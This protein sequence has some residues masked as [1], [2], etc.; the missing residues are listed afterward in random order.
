MRSSKVKFCQS[1]LVCVFIVLSTN[2]SYSH[3]SQFNS[4][5]SWSLLIGASKAS[6]LLNHEESHGIHQYEPL[7]EQIRLTDVALSISLIKELLKG[8]RMSYSLKT[9]I[10]KIDG[11]YSSNS[12]RNFR[13]EVSGQLFGLGGSVNYNCYQEFGFKIQPYIGAEIVHEFGNYRLSHKSSGNSLL[14]V[15]NYKENFVLIVA[16]VRFFDKSHKLMSFFEMSM[17]ETLTNQK[18][19]M[20]SVNGSSMQKD[21]SSV[22]VKRDSVIA[23]LG[24]G[25]T[26]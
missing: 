8:K 13:E 3:S 17:P 5:D 1:R 7:D 22:E 19:A 15:N 2:K 9:S 16:G 20:V 23:S 10:G 21:I 12:N 4:Y 26:F 6:R 14:T 25:L 18:N 24:F 11:S